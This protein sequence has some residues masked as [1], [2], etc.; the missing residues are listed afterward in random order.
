[1]D[2]RKKVRLRIGETENMGSR[3]KP[4]AQTT[5][6]LGR[7]VSGIWAS[8]PSLR[9]AAAPPLYMLIGAQRACSQGVESECVSAPLHPCAAGSVPVAMLG[10]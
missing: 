2:E 8:R 6:A 7:C 9:D 10:K 1:M 3:D 5:S 4:Q